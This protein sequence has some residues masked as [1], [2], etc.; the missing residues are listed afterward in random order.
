MGTKVITEAAVRKEI[1]ALEG[2]VYLVPS[3]KILSPAAKEYLN[4]QKIE[5]VKEEPEMWG[6]PEHMTHLD[7]KTLVPKDHPRIVFRGKLDSLQSN[8]ILTQTLLAESGSPKQLIEELEKIIQVLMEVMRC[9]VSGEQVKETGFLGLSHAELRAQSH[10]PEKY[11]Q[12][13]QMIMPN[14]SMGKPY[15]LI[16]RLRTAVRETEVSAVHAFWDGTAYQRKDIVEI[17]NRLSSA[18]HIIM[19]RMLAGYYEK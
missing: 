8:I 11:Y 5:I 6:K 1:H 19:C 16:N 2:K 3:G 12:I 18:M 10:D 14:Y 17:F 9:D 13:K 7:G 15:V 4:Q